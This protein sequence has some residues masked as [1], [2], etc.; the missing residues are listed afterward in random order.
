MHNY[1]D[2]RI[3]M[4]LNAMKLKWLMQPLKMLTH[5]FKASVNKNKF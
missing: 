4:T 2:H 3:L 5:S 1:C